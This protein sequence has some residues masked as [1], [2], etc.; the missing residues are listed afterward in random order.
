LSALIRKTTSCFILLVAF[1]LLTSNFSFSQNVG[2]E[3]IVAGQQYLKISTIQ[4]GLYY[5]T[6]QDL[7][8]AGISSTN[9]NPNTIQLWH[10]G[11]QVAIALKGMS[12]GVFDLQDSVIF[13][14]SK[15]DGTLDSLLYNPASSQ[16]HKYYNLHSDTSAYFLTSGNSPGKRFQNIPY[17]QSAN[18]VTWHWKNELSVF[19][20]SY[21]RGTIHNDVRL[22]D[23]TFGEGWTG[24]VV[25]K[26]P[27]ALPVNQSFDVPLSNFIST[28]PDVRL[29]ILLA[30]MN[31][32]LHQVSVIVG[33]L[34]SPIGS[35][36]IETFKGFNNRKFFTYVPSNLVTGN[37]LKVTIQVRG[38]NIYTDRVAV[39][40]LKVEY[41]QSINLNNT[42]L[43]F[44]N[45]E[46]K[47]TSNIAI[48]VDMDFY[49]ISDK[50]NIRTF[51]ISS[52]EIL[53]PSGNIEVLAS[54]S[55][56]VQRPL[57]IQKVSLGKISTLPSSSNYFIIS[58]PRFESQANEY[59]NYR[60]SPAG[61][62]YMVQLAMIQDLYNEFSYG[63]F[64]PLAV[65][66]YCRYISEKAN[67]EYLFIIGRGL[68]VDY[69][70][71]NKWYRTNPE[72]FQ[73]ENTWEYGNNFIPHAGN[74]TSD[75]NYVNGLKGNP[76]FLAAFPV[77]RLNA[78]YP[79]EVAAYLNKVKIH[80]SLGKDQLWRKNVLHLSGGKLQSEI[81]YFYKA[82]QHAE[83]LAED[84]VFGGKVVKHITKKV[85][86]YVED[87][88][89]ETVAEQV[90][91]GVSYVTFL[92]HDS[93]SVPDIDI[94]YISNT[95]YGYN[96]YGK[97]PML[98]MN[99][100]NTVN[101]RVPYSLPE[102]WLQTNN[103]G[104][105]LS[106]GHTD[107]AYIPLLERY[108]NLFYKHAFNNRE[109][110]EKNLSVGDIQILVH[111]DLDTAGNIYLKSMQQQVFLMGDPA[112]RMYTPQFPDYAITN[113]FVSS[114]NNL[115]VSAVSDSFK[116]KIVLDNYGIS[117]TKPVL[118]S[119]N[120]YIGNKV[121]QDTLSV[122]LPAYSDTI[123]INLKN[124]NAEE[125]SGINRF[126]IAIDP[127]HTFQEI[128]KNNNQYTL[129]HF[130]PSST[131]LPL[132]PQKYS[133][134][135]KTTVNLIAQSNDLMLEN[136]SYIFEI[137]TSYAFNSPVKMSNQFSSGALA[138]WS[139]V[140]LPGLGVKDS[141]VYYWRVRFSEIP[142]EGDTL[143]GQSSFVYVHNGQEGWSQSALPQIQEGNLQGLTVDLN[144]NSL[145]FSSL[146]ASIS[147]SS[148][149]KNYIGPDKTRP[150][151]YYTDLGINGDGIVFENRGGCGEG[152][153]A[154]TMN[155]SNLVPY[156]PLNLNNVCGQDFSG[157]RINSFTKLAQTTDVVSG[158]YHLIRYL[159]AVKPGDY[160]LLVSSGNSNFDKW[161]P[162]LKDKVISVLGAQYLDSLKT[163]MPYIILGKKDST[164]PIFENYGQPDEVIRF[165]DKLEGK[166]LAGIL[167][168][169]IIGPALQWQSVSYALQTSVGD[170][171][172]I[173]LLGVDIN[174]N[175]TVLYQDIQENPMDISALSSKE[176]SFVKL[177]A[178]LYDSTYLTAPILK[179]WNI[180]Y[181]PAPEGTMDPILAGKEQYKSF[182]KQ[183]GDSVQF[184]YVFSNISEQD[185]TDTLKVLYTTKNHTT[186]LV[187][188]DT[189]KLV[190]LKVDQSLKFKYSL[191]TVGWVGDIGVSAYV[192]PELLPEM[193][194]N[195]NIIESNFTITADK[196]N[197]I[198]DV[199][200]DGVH[201][202]DGDIVSP[203]PMISISL[204][205]EN[206][207]QIRNDTNGIDLFLK[208][209][210]SGC[211]YEKIRF[212]D[213]AI[214]Y[215]GQAN[216]RNN[217]FKIDYRPDLLQDGVHTLRVQG[218][219]MSGN[220]AGLQPYEI[221]FEVINES[222]IT[223]FY[224]YP[225]PFS[226]STRFVF[227]LT[228]SKIPEDIM[229][230]IMTV[231]GKVV[232]QIR[233]AELGPLRIGNNLT[234]YAWDG[235][236]E[237]GDQLANGVYLYQ[238][239]IK[240]DDEYKHRQTS[241]D[242]AFKKGFGKMYLL[243]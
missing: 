234:E 200:F 152:L 212:S 20:Q 92:G 13:F 181:Q 116:L 14:G 27:T 153:L 46:N 28:G 114:F 88:L 185:F 148:T 83:I 206:Q 33:D 169:P 162:E 193:Y 158:Q 63:E 50:R 53:L 135:N 42:Q 214:H 121:F 19:T 89:I 216:A 241:A 209:P 21:S 198:L 105:I 70:R 96:N 154:I 90:N 226:S 157:K 228:G 124:L 137:D 38:S 176:Y 59:A 222:S 141:L 77:G 99:G 18:K 24:T 16:P 191:N 76:D 192:N 143:W 39:S 109:V 145:G 57:K 34:A 106:L 197:P 68:D 136:A 187:K 201:L 189:V 196:I 75:L 125:V 91:K 160:I 3:W 93:P 117:H 186:G 129:R 195:N 41:P 7:I 115:P 23:F 168:S 67:P 30:G 113:A 47:S 155:K 224:P 174:G 11:E 84:T 128:S 207:F 199:T 66:N 179:H 164:N 49:D 126:T 29:E 43:Q 61:G 210:C 79:N 219:D 120:R 1:L 45:F 94:G 138:K 32:E 102:N 173:N 44:L 194:Y 140:S 95:L 223:N 205:D 65:R 122:I 40:Y 190:D 167:E 37:S 12:D 112:I 229:I 35:L 110:F 85:G 146:V 2:N 52:G 55:T 81:Q 6:G 8:D 230:N 104:A 182:T 177:V 150:A 74:P 5:I 97:Y 4:S 127:Q 78:K 149:G 139:N 48:P 238:V 227:T 147:A 236:D 51:E 242:K 159:D 235:R 108:L 156:F 144:T 225:N 183:E 131:V 213:P 36:P 180:T 178:E 211:Q 119:I 58:H 100:C 202:M 25:S 208:R 17:S 239:K 22:S 161:I 62:G 203:S 82:L 64:S 26:A 132:F 163:N 98:F 133:I 221:N 237:F 218:R 15:N 215:Y 56:L 101:G 134:V 233:K 73:V 165:T 175:E 123:S 151:I 240:G 243:K 217:N 231:T 86:S 72:A 54:P 69:Y 184:T 220:K 188:I 71:I 103:I 171:Y 142:A 232:R 107:L 166:E 87:K 170:A 130:F 31:D 9:W 172:K 118:V 10:R 111:K 80:E 60:N 204:R